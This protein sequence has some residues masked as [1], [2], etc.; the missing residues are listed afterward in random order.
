MALSA[1][2]RETDLLYARGLRIGTAL[3]LGLIA[4]ETFAYF[5]G[6]VSPYIP[7]ETLPR[8]WGLPMKDFLAAARVPAGWG[9]VALAGRGD[10]LNFIGIAVLASVTIACHLLLLA[11]FAGRRDRVYAAL[12]T[13]QVLVVAVAASGLLNSH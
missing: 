5:T 8:L 13:L 4:L 12:V 11:H 3:A 10:Y 6:I 9:W 1:T 7:F 2:G